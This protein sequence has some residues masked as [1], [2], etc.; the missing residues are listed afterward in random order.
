MASSSSSSSAAAA[1]ASASH[2]LASNGSQQSSPRHAATVTAAGSNAI[3]PLSDALF[4]SPEP[5]SSAHKLFASDPTLP[6]LSPTKNNVH[7]LGISQ[8]EEGQEP[9]VSLRVRRNRS[10]IKLGM[11]EKL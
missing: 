7:E 6:P 3:V 4:A 2:A 9:K 5:N 10:S 11:Y 8:T 1:A